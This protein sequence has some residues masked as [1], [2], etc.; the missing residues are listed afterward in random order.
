M[1]QR[2]AILL[3]VSGVLALFFLLG[4]AEQLTLDNLKARSSALLAVQQAQPVLS[5]AGFFVAYV[6]LTALSLPGAAIMTLAAG[7]VF[8]LG[9]GLLLVSFAS[10]LGAVLACGLARSLLQPLIA[11]RFQSQ[12]AM[13]NA[14]LERD[15]IFYLLS[16]RLVPAVPFFIVNLVFGLTRV[17]LARFYWVSQLGMLP[18]TAVYV[19]AGTELGAITRLGDILSPPLLGALLALG[20]FPWVA[21]AGLQMLAARR[22]LARFRR[23]KHFDDNVIVLGAG[24]GGLIAALIAAT[25]RAKVTLVERGEM[26]GDCLNRGCVPSKALLA[27]AHLASAQR[28]G[29]PGVKSLGVAIDFPAV[30]ARVQD[31]IAT[32]E[33]KDSAARYESLGVRVVKGEARILDPWTVEVHGERRTARRLIVATGGAPLLPPIPGLEA[34]DP[35]TSDSLWALETLPPRLLVLGAGPIGCE[36]AQSL[37]A[38]GASVALVDQAEQVL[39]REDRAVGAL[40]ASALVREG[41]TLHLGVRAE[42]FTPGAAL[43]SGTLLV[44]SGETVAFDRVL[45]AVGRRPVTAGL[46]LE[47]LGVRLR[48]NGALEVDETLRTSV[49]TIYGCGDVVGPYQFTH[50]A[51]DQAWVAAMNALFRPLKAFKWR[52]AVVPWITFTDPEVARV[53]LSE[54]EAAEK[55]IAVTV[56]Q[57]GYDDNDRAI[58]EGQTEGFIK[59]LTVPGKDRILGVTIVGARAGELLAPWV[60]AMTHGLGLKKIMG[61]IHAYPSYAELNKAVASAWRKAHAPEKALDLLRHWHALFR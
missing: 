51:S 40:L 24:S 30:M 31:A 61:T 59:V 18:G 14:G 25:A 8:G 44:S 27:S 36:L 35:L 16:L 17:S 15:G 50:M 39:P 55:G 2:I 9:T 42:A 23:P 11:E 33:P 3:A 19:Y 58:A 54:E 6:A 32:I 13:I 56:T 7:A 46:G 37:A 41:I 43:G 49:P 60:M 48:P 29:L 26:G 28:R 52:G 47:E 5:A 45:V 53:G 57:V 20:L 10:S 21:R 4:G 1:K 38:L 22:A 12:L 34:C